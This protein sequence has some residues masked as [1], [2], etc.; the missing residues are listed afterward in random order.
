MGIDEEGTPPSWAPKVLE[1]LA[2]QRREQRWLGAMIGVSESM[3]GKMLKGTR[4]TTPAQYAAIAAV[5]G[6]PPHWLEPDGVAA[7]PEKK[8]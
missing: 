6:V 3:I 4:R 5:T 1:L 8:A 2:A 7:A